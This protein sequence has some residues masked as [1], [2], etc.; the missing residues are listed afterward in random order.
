MLVGHC[1][2]AA[3]GDFKYSAQGLLDLCCSFTSN[4][5]ARI[6]SLGLLCPL[7]V[8]PSPWLGMHSHRLSSYTALQ[9]PRRPSCLSCLSYSP[10][11]APYLHL[12][13]CLVIST[14]MFMPPAAPLPLNS[15]HSWIASTSH[16]M[17][18]VTPMSKATHW[19]WCAQLAELPPI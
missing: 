14:S 3:D 5:I 4:S 18:K 6:T 17:L 13:S 15:C 16:S 2:A 7:S 12:H 1:S 11:S 19:T 8:Q 9:K 10:P